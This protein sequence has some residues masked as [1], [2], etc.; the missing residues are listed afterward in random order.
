MESAL[1]R[2]AAGEEDP[3][4]LACGGIQKAATIS[5]GQQLKPEVL[6]A[7]GAAAGACEIFLAVGTSL[8]VQPAAAL[9][10]VAVAAGARLVIVN[11]EQTP[12]DR[13]A[14]ALV[15]DPIGEA[16]PRIVGA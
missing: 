9:C 3:R 2:V 11:A 15:R 7:A 5:F 12:Y 16:L 14:D 1:A 6:R 10:E 8:R 13:W 4:C